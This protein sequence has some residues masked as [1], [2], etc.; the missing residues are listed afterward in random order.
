MN[1]MLTSLLSRA[2]APC[3]LAAV[4]VVSG[5]ATI[6]ADAGNDARD[7]IESFNRQVFEFNDV[8]DRAVLKPVAEAYRFVLP[9]PVRDCLGNAFSN[10]REPSNAINNLLQGKPID[11][12]SDTCRFVVNSTVGLLG[13]FDPARQMGLEK[14]NEDFGQTLGRWGAGPGPYLVLPILGPSSVRDAVGTL[15]VES[16]LDPNFYINDIPVRNWIL[17]TRVV[18]Q[19]A[20]LLQA[21]DLISGAA[22]DKYRFI[23]DGYLQ[24]RRSLV[25]D[26][27]PPPAADELDSKATA[28][29]PPA[30]DPSVKKELVPPQSDTPTK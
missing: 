12:I 9:E 30:A 10:L 14:H 3:L 5:C 21:D 25:Y 15:V 19:R 8:V 13:C 7:P 26:G 29:S 27:S 17:G 20:Q 18:D 1:H 6:P 28:G 2:M 24:R 16:Y 23:R 11:A 4:A 22:L